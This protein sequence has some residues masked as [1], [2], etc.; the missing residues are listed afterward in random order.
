MRAD[1]EQSNNRK[2]VSKS[3]F[4]TVLKPLKHANLEPGCIFC[5]AHSQKCLPER[6]LGINSLVLV[7]VLLRWPVLKYPPMAGFQMSTEDT[8]QFLPIQNVAR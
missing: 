5:G 6:P 3:A 8:V 7:L 4:Y 1:R 2:K